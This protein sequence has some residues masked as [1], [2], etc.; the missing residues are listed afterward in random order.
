MITLDLI[1]GSQEWRAKRQEC[2]TASEAS[3]MMGA[4]KYQTRDQLLAAKSTGIAEEIDSAKQRLF[5]RG[6]DAEAINRPT[7]EEM[8]GQELYPVTGFAEIE[9]L[10][11]LA[12]FDGI[13]MDETIIFEHK[14]A[15]QNLIA[16]VESGQ[17]EPHYYWQLEQQ[18]LVS[19]AEKAIFACGDETGIIAWLQY[20]PVPGRKEQLIA[21]WHQFAKD[22]ET[23]TPKARAEKAIAQPVEAL[24]AINYAIDLS[25]GISIQSN[26]EVFKLAAQELVERSKQ[27]LMT[28][29]DFEDAKARV[30]QCENAE[31]NIASLIQRVLGELGDVNKFKE[32]MESI[33]EWIRQSRLNQDRQIKERLT[34]RKAEIKAA[35][36]KA[37]DDYIEWANMNL[38]RVSLPAISCDL[39][40][41]LYKKSSFASMESAVNDAVANF[42]IAADKWSAHL[43]KSLDIFDQAA[44]GYTELFRDLQQLCEKDTDSLKAIVKV[45]TDEFKIKEQERIEA[46]AKRLAAQKAAQ[47][48]AAQAA[49]SA[50]KAA[51]EQAP[52]AV[53]ANV[54]PAAPANDEPPTYA[55]SSFG[56]GSPRTNVA[57]KSLPTA[58]QVINAVAIHFNMQS[59]D[60]ERL[61]IDL[62][63]A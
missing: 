49:E 7:V 48:A 28:D 39:D 50:A 45:R 6:H 4:S 1:Q 47:E 34:T 40:A 18:L 37:V 26:L 57:P 25:N 36:R 14:L 30:K 59:V 46:E 38:G 21:G 11:L 3:A 19:G 27:L 43:T 10:P 2:Y 60:A 32:D 54:Q 9:G 35:G 56:G 16:A 41:A 51:A 62:F 58:E 13:T 55:R 63:R 44:E 24:P 12:S 15:N 8:I 20:S 31:K 22:L 17:L 29:Q 5:Q 52:V 33:K 23:F 42:K 53:I 61:L